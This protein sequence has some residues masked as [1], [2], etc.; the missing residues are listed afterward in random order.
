MRIESGQQMFQHIEN[1]G[2]LKLNSEG[3]LETQSAAG[4]FFQK[5]GDAF[6]S[7][8][9][10]GRAAI[11]TRNTRLHEAMA[12]M[13]RRDALVNP[14]Q[15]EIQ[16]PPITQIERN[17]M[18]ASLAMA[19]ELAK[20][21][22]ESRAAARALVLHQL[23]EHG[24]LNHNA[25]TV[26]ANIQQFMQ[27]INSDPVLSNGLKCAFSLSSARLQPMMN[28]VA[29]SIRAE[30]RKPVEQASVSDGIH[31]SYIQDAR[32]NSV[33][34]IN[35]QPVNKDDL[36]GQLK[37]L[38]PDEKMSAFISFAASQAGIEGGLYEHLASPS[39]TNPNPDSPALPE[40][41]AKGLRLG[42]PYHKYE[43]NIQ[44]GKAT[45]RLDMDVALQPQETPN[46]G[47][48]VGGSRYAVTMEID[49]NQDMTGKDMPDFTLSGEC[50]AFGPDN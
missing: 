2:N 47:H 35:G 22:P 33:R 39:K 18:C 16:R 45:I 50:T 5:I 36:A 11:E 38:V 28:E 24:V 31:S 25:A 6:R 41:I 1:G 43:L 4:R 26:R 37:A 48:G 32:R 40:L 7:L 29:E 17:R 23:R 49:L 19:G 20:L 44:N 30:F 46:D 8:S 42:T 10:S 12:D 34:S 3:Q 9:A 27:R 13:V 14:A 21:P 15:A